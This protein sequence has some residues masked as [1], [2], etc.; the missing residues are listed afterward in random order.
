VLD[1]RSAVQWR[2][3]IIAPNL[4]MEHAVSE[5]SSR[6]RRCCGARNISFGPFLAKGVRGRSMRARQ[7]M[8]AGSVRCCVRPT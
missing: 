6:G 8:A 3:P 1:E 7:S 4:F 5:T 2:V